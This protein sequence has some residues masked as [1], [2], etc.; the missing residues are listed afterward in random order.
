MGFTAKINN[1]LLYEGSDG[2]EA[3]C[4]LKDGEVA[5]VTDIH[6]QGQPFQC[7]MFTAADLRWLADY[8]DSQRI[9]TKP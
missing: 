4:I 3:F 9:D 7:V 1:D 8:V 6:M 2:R 5:I